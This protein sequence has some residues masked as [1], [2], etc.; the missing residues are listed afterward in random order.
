M[1]G[2]AQVTINSISWDVLL[3]PWTFLFGHLTMPI[4]AVMWGWGI[5]I[6]T[7]WFA[8][9][10]E[11]AIHAVSASHARMS[12]VFFSVGLIL[13]ALNGYSD[14]NY[15]TLSSGWLGHF[16]FSV[17]TSGLVVWGLV[18]GIRFIEKAFAVYGGH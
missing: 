16:G 3:Q 2:G 14:F 6:V 11:I 15:G 8:I 17:I 4:Q 7:L 5:E 9:A 1:I 13:M 18:I 12:K 10:A